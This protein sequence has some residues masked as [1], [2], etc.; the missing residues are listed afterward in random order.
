MVWCDDAGVTCRRWNWR[1]ARRT[2]LREDTTTALFI[3]DALDPMTDEALHAAADDLITHL[4]RLGTRRPRRSP[5]DHQPR[6]LLKETDMLIHPWDAALDPPNGRHWLASTDR[7]GMLV[8]N[9]LDP[10]QAPLVVPTHFTLAGDELLI[11]LARPNPVWPHLEAAAEVRLAVIGD[12]A[13]IPTYWRAKAGGPDE[14]GVPTSYYSAVQF[15]CRPTVV[16]DPAGQGRHPHR[17]AR[18][19]PTRRPPRAVAADSEP[20]GR[21]LPGIR[22][23]RLAVLR[24]DAK[25]KYDDHNPVEHRERVI[26]NLQ[27]R[28]HGLDAGAAA[29]QR[30]R[31]AAIGDWRTR[32]TRTDHPD[33]HAQEQGQP[34]NPS[35]TVTSQPIRAAPSVLLAHRDRVRSREVLLGALLSLRGS[36]SG[37]PGSGCQRGHCL[38]D[39]RVASGELD[40]G[41]V[42]VGVEQGGGDEGGYVVA[43]HCAV[44]DRD[45]GVDAASPGVVEQVAGSHDEEV[46]VRAGEVDVGGPLDRHVVLEPFGARLVAQCVH[47]HRDQHEA[48]YAGREAASAAF[49]R[50]RPSIA[51]VISAPVP[52]A[53]AL[54]TTASCPARRSARVATES[55]MRSPVTGVPPA[56]ADDGVLAAGPVHAG[57][58]VALLR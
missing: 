50:P 14:D 12:Y 52:W 21:M 57:D 43:G 44:G 20:Y 24:V 25:F 9:N 55:S 4:T 38:I 10:A 6:H 34:M 49:S 16:D 46:Q 15:V 33:L 48:A 29:Q 3:L 40:V 23:V 31:L 37:T 22:G 18:R 35:D 47:E 17:P 13:Y 56:L 1:Q 51:V 36:C 8:V 27:E 54:K 58:A 7:F 30:R 5:A 11:H 19:L 41:A 53:P 26:D 45:A 42:E 32:R 2:Q 28:G 39:G